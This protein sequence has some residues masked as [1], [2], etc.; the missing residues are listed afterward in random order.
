MKR[1]VSTTDTMELELNEEEIKTAILYLLKNK[2]VFTDEQ[3]KNLSVE[4]RIEGQCNTVFANVEAKVCHR[5]EE[6]APFLGGAT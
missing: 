2:M 3:S 5:Y 6:P 4:L 1:R